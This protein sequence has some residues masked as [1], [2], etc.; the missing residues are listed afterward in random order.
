MRQEQQ[1]DTWSFSSPSSRAA[2]R[3]S[4]ERRRQQVRGRISLG[5]PTSVGSARYTNPSSSYQH[6]FHRGSFQ[7]ANANTNG[8]G[9]LA[10]RAASPG[11]TRQNSDRSND[12]TTYHHSPTHNRLSSGSIGRSSPEASPPVAI[13]SGVASADRSNSANPRFGA[14]PDQLWL[15]HD[16]LES[17]SHNDGNTFFSPGRADDF[18]RAIS[19]DSR[20]GS[21]INENAQPSSSFVD[22]DPMPPG[23]GGPLHNQANSNRR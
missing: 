23:L 12:S 19:F 9:S 2:Q 15:D 21:H 14:F 3:D 17:S 4:P 1:S 10:H 7:G 5:R 22:S 18:A 8:T 13:G 16:H 6:S 11:F 20:S